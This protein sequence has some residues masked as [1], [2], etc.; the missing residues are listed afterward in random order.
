MKT[1]ELTIN[2]GPQ[3][4]STHG[5]FRMILDVD[6]E[7][8]RKVEPVIGYLHRG[9]EKLG[10]YKMY[11]SGLPLTDRMDYLSSMSNNLVYSR[12]V[13]QLCRIEVPIRAQFI[14]VLMCELNRIASHGMAV[15]AFAQDL[16][17]TTPFV[18]AFRDRERILDLFEEV[19][20]ARLTYSFIR[21]GGV[22]GDLPEGYEKR[23]DAFLDIM[24]ENLVEYHQLMTENEI[25]QMRAKGIGFI[26]GEDAVSYSL[27]G[28]NLRGSGVPRDL[29]KDDPYE[30]YDQLD[31]SICTQGGGDVWSRYLV[32]MRELEESIKIVR[33]IVE[34]I[35]KTG[36]FLA[37]SPNILK[38]PPGEVYTCIES[39]RGQVGVYMVSD[40]TDKP[41]RYKVRPPSFIAVGAL[42]TM[43]LGVK[44]ADAIAVLGSIDIVLGEV[45]R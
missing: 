29:R 16:G 43:M 22:A 38:P 44:V 11:K 1:E 39:P 8:V 33:Q 4:P 45:D 36:E 10:E 24:E 40:G 18:F 32:R 30:I 12:A 9:F 31:F 37:R 26:S 13:E 19:C 7:T 17:S 41:Y 3:H 5:V 42:E 14:R 34:K 20:G 35:P 27:S 25:F 21:P 2:F 28:P 6:G 15:G 23:V